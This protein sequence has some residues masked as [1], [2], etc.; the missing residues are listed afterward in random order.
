LNSL[1]SAKGVGYT[2][3]TIKGNYDDNL[4]NKQRIV[5][6]ANASGT[7]TLTANVAELTSVQNNLPIIL[8]PSTKNTGAV[9]LNVNSFGALPVN[10]V[11]NITG[12]TVYTSLE[13]GDLQPNMP[14]LIVKDSTG[15]RYLASYFGEDFARNSFYD[16]GNGVYGTV[17]SLLS[18]V[19]NATYTTVSLDETTQ[20]ASTTS[21]FSGIADL[22]IGGASL[23]QSVVN[24]DFSAGTTGWTGVDST[25]SAT[26][27][28]LSVTGT[29]TLNFPR[30]TKVTQI[31]YVASA[32]VFLI[33]KVGKFF[34]LKTIV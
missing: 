4:I 27:K 6:T 19:V 23:V 30:V 24:G 15:T 34:L 29:G 16:Y 12:S 13:D 2:N 18:G 22:T 9:T 31:P 7:N 28:V 8:I 26:S 3:Q 20:I 14:I 10:K 32:K 17:Q 1:D 11:R 5:Y 21:S 25:L 33:A